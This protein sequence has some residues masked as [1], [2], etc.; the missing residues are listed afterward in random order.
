MLCLLL[1]IG[2]ARLSA[3]I[4]DPPDN[5]N[6]TGTVSGYH[7]YANYEE[8]AYCGDELADVLVGTIY[9]HYECHFRNGNFVWALH[10]AYGEFVST[11]GS[12]EIFKIHDI[13]HKYD[14][15]REF[16]Y[17]FFNFIGNQGSHYVGAWRWENNEPWG[18]TVIRAKCPGSN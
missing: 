12:G 4:P 17:E 13:P 2:L 5:K 10:Q 1:G 8:P 14:P 11:S 7:E 16:Q 18:F 9:V 15:S 6:G 3:Q